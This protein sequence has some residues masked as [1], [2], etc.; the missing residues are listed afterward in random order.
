VALLTNLVQIFESTF[1]WSL[2]MHGYRRDFL[3]FSMQASVATASTLL[4]PQLASS[5]P[6]YRYRL[7]HPYP[8]NL[9][10]HTHALAAAERILKESN[11]QLEIKVFGNSALGGDTQMISQVRSGALQ[12]YSGAGVIVSSVAPLAAI[13][14][15]GFAFSD[16]QSVWKALDGELGGVVRNSFSPLGLYAFE[17]CWDTGF[18]QIS[19]STRPIAAPS[20]LA[21]FKIRVP[22]SRA[23]TSLFQG[24]G[25]AP[26]SVN[27]AEVYSALQ[28]KVVDGQENS[29]AVFSG[30]KFYE[31]QKFVSMT[32][33]MW[34]G[35]WMIANARAWQTLPPSL[36]EI[37][38]RNF[39]DAAVAQR[40]ESEKANQ[41]LRDTLTS[42]R[43]IVN[44]V[45]PARF[46]A[47]LQQSGY[48]KDW[49]ERYGVEAWGRLEKY[50]G[51]LA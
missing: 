40:A 35:S 46:R 26:T 3:K 28:T 43:V 30:A 4:L 34:D 48:Y 15:V 17:K 50:T 13:S 12:F 42:H 47:V 16:Y 7:G 36:Q 23:Y 21:G 5:A 14:G 19:S 37:V 44:S 1:Y 45:D 20:D 8:E 41:Q 29:L 49:A 9:P 31:V 24:L 39:N 33:H 32:N 18:R 22:V 2:E 51:K 10:V 25:A 27:L 11:G 38:T 6:T